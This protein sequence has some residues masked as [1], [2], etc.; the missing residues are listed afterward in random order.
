MLP[1]LPPPAAANPAAPA[2]RGPSC[3]PACIAAAAGDPGICVYG[4]A[5][6]LLP[7]LAAAALLLLNKPLCLL[8]GAVGVAH[9]AWSDANPSQAPE[10]RTVS[11]T[12]AVPQFRSFSVSGTM[13]SDAARKSCLC[14][15]CSPGPSSVILT[16]FSCCAA[17]RS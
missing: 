5:P 4:P 3:D 11:D 14:G 7:A 9:H 13:H 17:H 2:A 12:A 1:P 10:A 16:G 8:P 15:A 6:P